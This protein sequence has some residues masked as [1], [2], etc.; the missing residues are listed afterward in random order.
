MLHALRS[1]QTNASLSVLVDTST[2]SGVS[3]GH[4][5]KNCVWLSVTAWIKIEQ[6]LT[7]LMRANMLTN[8]LP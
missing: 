3:S 8:P 7:K 4:K 5:S 6:C 1:Q 2:S